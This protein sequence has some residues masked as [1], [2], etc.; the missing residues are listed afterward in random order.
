ME[1]VLDWSQ[2]VARYTQNKTGSVGLNNDE[3]SG[4]GKNEDGATQGDHQ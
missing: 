4:E 1:S 2:V 3:K